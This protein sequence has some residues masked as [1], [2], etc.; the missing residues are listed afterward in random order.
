M[1][2]VRRADGHADIR[3]ATNSVK[4]SQPRRQ[5]IVEA[6]GGVNRM[7]DVR[8]V[9]V[10]P[11]IHDAT[12][13]V[14][15][16]RPRRQEIVEA[17]GGVNRMAD[18][19]CV[20]V[21]TDIRD[22]TSSVKDSEPRRQE[23]VEASGGRNRMIAVMGVG[24]SADE[25][26]SR[27]SKSAEPRGREFVEASGGRNRN[28]VV[29]G[30]NASD[31]L[32]SSLS[33]CDSGS[34]RR[35][36]RDPSTSSTHHRSSSNYW[37][38]DPRSSH[39][40]WRRDPR[41]SDSRGNIHS[42]EEQRSF[43]R[44]E[45]MRNSSAGMPPS[46]LFEEDERPVSHGWKPSIFDDEEDRQGRNRN[47]YQNNSRNNNGW[48][49]NRKQAPHRNNNRFFN[50]RDQDAGNNRQDSRRGAGGHE[51]SSHASG[52]NVGSDGNH[53]SNSQN[54][55]FVIDR[56]GNDVSNDQQNKRGLNEWGQSPEAKRTRPGDEQESST[57]NP[58]NPSADE[59]TTN[60]TLSDQTTSVGKSNE[61]AKSKKT[62]SKK[63]RYVLLNEMIAEQLNEEQ[64]KQEPIKRMEYE[65][66]KAREAEEL[67]KDRE[68]A[69]RDVFLG[70][71]SCDEVDEPKSLAGAVEGAKSVQKPW[72]KTER[73]WNEKGQNDES[74]CPSPGDKN[75]EPFSFRLTLDD[76]ENRAKF[77]K[78]DRERRG[79]ARK[80]KGGLG[81]KTAERDGVVRKSSGPVETSVPTGS[82]DIRA[83][84]KCRQDILR[85]ANANSGS[86]GSSSNSPTTPTE[87]EPTNNASNA[88]RAGTQ[89]QNEAGSP[90]I[91]PKGDEVDYQHDC[92]V[93]FRY[94]Q[95]PDKFRWRACR[96]EM[97][98]D[99]VKAKLP[100]SRFYE[101]NL[102]TSGNAV[103]KL[104]DG[105][106]STDT[107]ETLKFRA[108]AEEYKN[109]VR[110]VA[111]VRKRRNKK[112]KKNFMK[113]GV[114]HNYDQSHFRGRSWRRS[115]PE[116][117]QNEPPA[118]AQNNNT[119]DY[120]EQP[121]GVGRGEKRFGDRGKP[122]ASGEG[123]GKRE[124]SQVLRPAMAARYVRNASGNQ[125]T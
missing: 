64:L 18:V 109:A 72:N 93:V 105:D 62:P 54:R 42:F 15:D 6:S 30:S 104:L 110:R 53:R 55:P 91:T 118:S 1:A 75:A 41:H 12:N 63:S 14:K 83:W 81:S 94:S 21:H 101:F 50:Y 27:A 13:S 114:D 82:F 80:R 49:P 77:A 22:A 117:H 11:D 47:R 111:N 23:V 7:A 29:V 96:K 19:M 61:N 85:K 16:S 52:R 43:S 5:E 74:G 73:K 36:E 2:D 68:R 123:G 56:N 119:E 112:N 58:A 8:R 9:N 87:T 4:D 100:D 107:W 60:V 3:D 31:T 57:V 79:P 98:V 84:E 102:D 115:P 65:Q 89:S 124:N 88:T 37:S 122:G 106:F 121:E 35:D 78:A 125:R 33:N 108:I 116:D 38:R 40:S 95:L 44:R 66:R 39:Y 34:N 24:V 45:G 26:E 20:N 99:A 25:L 32:D 92:A 97:L 71:D 51:R 59:E 120:G 48:Q 90:E 69:D 17:S 67:R 103:H 70:E 76:P 10:H 28:A 113:F 86:N 46:G